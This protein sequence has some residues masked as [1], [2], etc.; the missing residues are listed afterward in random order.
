MDFRA[1]SCASSLHPLSLVGLH[2]DPAL[3]LG[4]SAFA[5]VLRYPGSTTRTFV[6]ALYLQSR[7]PTWFSTDSSISAPSRHFPGSL[8]V[9]PAAKPPPWL[10]PPSSLLWTF[11]LTILLM[12]LAWLLL[13]LS[14]PCP[15]CLPYLRP[16]KTAET[17]QNDVVY[18]PYHY[19][20]L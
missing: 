20:A 1:F 11:I 17:T 5:S 18:M 14:L 7:G 2:P 16:H 9:D 19:V 8:I 6:I 15:G 12:V 3:V 13:S 4:H 10:P